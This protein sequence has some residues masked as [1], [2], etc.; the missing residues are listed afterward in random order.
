MGNTNYFQSPS[1]FFDLVPWCNT[2]HSP[3]KRSR[4]SQRCQLVVGI[5]P[6]IPGDPGSELPYQEKGV[7]SH[8]P[9]SCL[10]GVSH[11]PDSGLEVLRS[12]FPGSP[13]EGEA[14]WQAEAEPRPSERGDLSLPWNDLSLSEH[15]ASPSAYGL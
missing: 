3:A 5:V 6:D 7:F 2:P 10:I 8:L 15:P 4:L 13:W 14:A 12:N 11:F 1:E 9:G